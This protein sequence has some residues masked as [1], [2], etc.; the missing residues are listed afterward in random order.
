MR[1]AVFRWLERNPRVKGLLDVTGSLRADDPA[2]ARGVAVGLFI[3]LTPVFGVQTLLLV[4]V[5]IV[6][7]A[8]FPVAFLVSCI[9]NPFTIGPMVLT[10]NALGTAM[11]GPFVQSAI[12]GADLGSEAIEETLV[13][14]FGGMLVS[15][16]ASLVGYSMALVFLYRRAERRSTGTESR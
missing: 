10:F 7:R 2:I 16:P 14:F 5:C 9:S 11:I 4:L 3:A 12:A 6:A 8:N 1:A 13:T 15:V